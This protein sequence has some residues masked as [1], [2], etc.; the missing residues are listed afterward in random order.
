MSSKN[1]A[2]IFP[3]GN[4]LLRIDQESVSCAE[5]LFDHDL[6]EKHIK[7]GFLCLSSIE[8][9]LSG[10]SVPNL[11]AFLST[12]NLKVSGKKEVITPSIQVPYFIEPRSIQSPQR[13]GAKC[14]HVRN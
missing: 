14:L 8:Y 10:V 12:H 11:K 7:E 13:R 9:D 3:N 5:K 2:D 6:I 4:L 1:P